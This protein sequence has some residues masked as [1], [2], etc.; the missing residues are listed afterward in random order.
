MKS[1]CIKVCVM[2]PE[3]GLCRGCRR[4][5]EEIGAW[6]AMTDAEREAVLAALPKRARPAGSEVAEVPVPPLS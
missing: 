4:S 5:L 2:E 6:S 3:S 1:P